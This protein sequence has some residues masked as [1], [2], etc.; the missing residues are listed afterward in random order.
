MSF[1]HQLIDRCQLRVVELADL[2]RLDV[3]HVGR[4]GVFEVLECFGDEEAQDSQAC[5]LDCIEDFEA[6]WSVL[7]WLALSTQIV[8]CLQPVHTPEKHAG[9]RN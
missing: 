1:D 9:R 8:F 4:A 6:V 3:G 2:A 7:V 5:C